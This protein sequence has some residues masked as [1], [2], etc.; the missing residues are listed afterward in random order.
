MENKNTNNNKEPIFNLKYK[1]SEEEYLYYNHLY[2]SEEFRGKRKKANRTGILE[3]VIGTAL[4]LFVLFT[5]MGKQNRGLFSILAAM[6]FGLGIYSLLFYKVI[7][8]NSL[9]KAAKGHYQKSKYLTN[10]IE[11]L[12]YNNRLE[13]KAVETENTY[14]WNEI[15]SFAK[16]EKL[17]FITIKGQRSILIPKNALGDDKYILEEFFETISKKYSKEYKEW[18]E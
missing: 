3:L 9:T 2:A 8:P 7:F 16:S 11:L 10:E 15:E 14:K 13:E 1:I 4:I 17:Y 18:K 12:F 5:E 6:G